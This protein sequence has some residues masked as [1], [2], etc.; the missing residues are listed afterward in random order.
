MRSNFED[1]PMTPVSVEETKSTSQQETNGNNATAT[2]NNQYLSGLKLYTLLSGLCLA[3]L[4][5]A[6]DTAILATVSRSLP[7]QNLD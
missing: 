5:V 6:L 2:P 1:L 3:V 7:E 4:L